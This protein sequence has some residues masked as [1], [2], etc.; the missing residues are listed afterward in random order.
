MIGHDGVDS[1]SGIGSCMYTH[2]ETGYTSCI[3]AF[4][5]LA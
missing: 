2:M 4:D 3:F 1:G 5:V